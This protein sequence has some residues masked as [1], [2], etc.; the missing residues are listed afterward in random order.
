MIE[1][2]PCDWKSVEKI[3]GVKIAR[4]SVLYLQVSATILV[5]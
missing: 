4:L 3:I 1:K 5:F 2:G